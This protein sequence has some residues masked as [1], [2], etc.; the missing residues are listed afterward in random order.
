M[1][2]IKYFAA[3]AVIAMTSFATFAAEPVDQQQ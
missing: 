1:K 3:A 2:S